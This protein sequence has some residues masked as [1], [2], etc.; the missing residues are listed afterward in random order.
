MT[1][2]TFI[3][4]FTILLFLI[5]CTEKHSSCPLSVKGKVDSLSYAKGFSIAHSPKYTIVTVFN[6]WKKG[7]VYDRYYLVKDS[8]INTPKDGRKVIIPLRSVM[9]NSA[10][11]IGFL[12]ALGEINK[13]TGVC[14]S[15]YI[16]NPTILNKVKQGKVKD[17]GDAFNLNIEKLLML[18]PQVVFT[19]AYNADDENSKRIRQTGLNIIYNIEWQEKTLLGRAEW[20]KFMGAFFDKE[21]L[22]NSI[23]NRVI[24]QYNT[25]KA[26]VTKAANRPSIMSG[27]DFRGTWS[28]SGGKS[29]NGQLFHDAYASY[30]YASDSSTSSIPSNIEQVLVNFSNADI[31]VGSD[32]KSFKELGD[33]NPRYKLFKAFRNKQVYNINR[34]CNAN[35]GNDYWES[36]VVRPDL[37]LSDM[38]KIV[39]P[40]I[41]PNYQLTYM[42]RLK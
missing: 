11:H 3:G 24:K 32:A 1:K 12:D 27:Q 42:E 23:F 37:L 5:A 22:A 28:V 26:K 18:H 20:I 7:V 36:G 33:I 4:I 8:T 40:E 13:I 19:T 31:W 35:G 25:I 34:R 15:Q 41:L 6:P 16:Y 39:H 14:S 9:V 29:F 38:I 21:K 2:K 17:L 10:T 30:F